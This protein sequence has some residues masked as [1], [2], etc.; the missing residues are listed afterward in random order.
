M[1]RLTRVILENKLPTVFTARD[2]KRLEPSDNVRYLQMK[3][4][5]SAGDIIK[6]QRGVYILNDTLRSGAI[7]E[8]YLA[9]RFNPDSYISMEAALWLEGWMPSYFDEITSVTSRPSSFT[10]T[11]VGRFSYVHIPQ[12]KLFAGVRV[13]FYGSVSHKQAKPLKALADYVYDQQNQW[14]S[15]DPLVNVLQIEPEFLKNLTAQEFD[16]IQGN[17]SS[18]PS[19]E[20]FLDGIRRELQV[21]EKYSRMATKAFFTYLGYLFEN[22]GCQ[23]F[24]WT[25]AL[26]NEYAL[27][28]YERFVKNHCGHKVGT[29]H[30]AQ[31]GYTGKISDINLYE[32]TREEYFNWKGRNFK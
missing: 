22:R 18:A 12:K 31:K 13:V 10:Q 6:L 28:Q 8:Y 21:G 4:A 32:L 25:V 29:R 16:E 27:K 20:A 9:N 15:L 23:V 7:D 2:L 3:R 17:Y 11:S 19:V 1:N 14:I 30:H 5:M 24:N 26:Q